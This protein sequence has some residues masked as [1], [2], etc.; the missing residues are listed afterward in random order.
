[1][2]RA[3]PSPHTTSLETF[4]PLE[5]LFMLGRSQRTGTLRVV[6]SAGDLLVTLR[7]GR[8]QRVQL[9]ELSGPAALAAVVADPRGHFAFEDDPPPRGPLD[10]SVEALALAALRELPTP[11]LPFDGPARLAEGVSEAS[12][13]LAERERQAL[14]PVLAGTPLGRL[15]AGSEARALAAR[16]LRL[17]LLV[18][19]KARV[20]RLTLALD[21]RPARAASLDEKI[22]A[23]WTEDTGSPVRK[24]AVRT[25]AGQ[26]VSLA[27][28]AQP[29]LGTSLLLPREW[30][31]QHGLRSGES[32]LVRPG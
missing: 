1:M 6:R 27:V 15:G 30:L 12:L 18:Q 11:E 22:L 20:A 2:D 25:D 10:L 31:M 21:R 5:L 4:D 28:Q 3:R 29:G 24:V 13:Q 14:A 9:N 8:V 16:L 23:R 19:R 17:G 26:V 7:Q 32:V